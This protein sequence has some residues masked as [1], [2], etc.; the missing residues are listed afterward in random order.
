MENQLVKFDV[1]SAEIA[2]AMKPAMELKISCA[3][4]VAKAQET[5]VIIKKLSKAVED[6][7]KELVGPLNDNVKQ[8][9]SYAK[10]V[11]ASLE[12]AESHIKIQ[13]IKYNSEQEKIRQAEIAK[14]EAERKAREAE[15]KRIEDEKKKALQSHH[16]DDFEGFI[17][18]QE[19]KKK[20]A[21]ALQAESERLRIEN[22]RQAKLK[23]MEIESTKVSGVRKVWTFEV[24]N[25][26]RVPVEF[27][28]LDEVKIRAAIHA[29]AREIQGLR[30]YQQDQMAFRG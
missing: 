13:L 2:L 9:N 15:L 3:A 26:G 7:R 17:K 19:T 20:E 18:D 6:H 12:S 1:L 22:E 16:D 28:K 4:D 21:L 10:K 8:I 24:E 5:G 29:G 25:I 11:S 27:I 14:T 30:I 23:K